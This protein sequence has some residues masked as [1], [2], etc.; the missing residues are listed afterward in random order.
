MVAVA[1]AIGRMSLIY[2][3]FEHNGRRHSFKSAQYISWN[4]G[5][6]VRHFG[7]FD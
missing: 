4:V 7:I 2:I 1:L 6:Y 5:F 3:Y